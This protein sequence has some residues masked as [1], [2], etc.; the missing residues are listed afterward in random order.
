M[1]VHGHT[2]DT[3]GVTRSG[4]RFVSCAAGYEDDCGGVEEH[5]AVLRALGALV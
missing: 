5:D 2:H 4:V 1:W 3:Y